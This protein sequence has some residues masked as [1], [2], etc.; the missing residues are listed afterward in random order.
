MFP[1]LLKQG[2]LEFQNFSSEP[3]GIEYIDWINPLFFAN[4]LLV[5]YIVAIWE[6]YFRSTYVVLLRY[7]GK[8]V[9]A[10][11]RNKLSQHQ[12]ESVA[13]GR[14]DVEQ[15]VA[16]SLSFQR[17]SSISSNF[18]SIEPNLDSKKFLNDIE[19]VVDRVYGKWDRTLVSAQ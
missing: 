11:K 3:T 12:L 8:R 9:S 1:L 19:V 7:S 2:K 16:E 6:E 14:Q 10:L 4:K 18:E 5:P 15:A 17:P 13:A